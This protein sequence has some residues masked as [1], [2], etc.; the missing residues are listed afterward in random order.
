MFATT[1]RKKLCVTNII[2]GAEGTPGVNSTPSSSKSYVP[3]GFVSQ[4]VQIVMD[5]R[6]TSTRYTMDRYTAISS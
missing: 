3:S 4:I 1:I 5:S 2:G 6:V